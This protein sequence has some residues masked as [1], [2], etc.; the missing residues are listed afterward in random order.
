MGFAIYI[1]TVL[2]T[3]FVFTPIISGFFWMFTISIL[4]VQSYMHHVVDYLLPDVA[5]ASG[6]WFAIHTGSLL[7]TLAA[8]TFSQFMMSYELLVAKSVLGL[9]YYVI[10]ERKW[11][12]V[13]AR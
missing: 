2:D 8:P 5:D 10:S 9:L 3:I 7:A 12:K 13:L 4:V 11:V 1:I 6:L